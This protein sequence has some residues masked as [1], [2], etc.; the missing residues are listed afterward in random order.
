MDQISL[1]CIAIMSPGDMGHAVGRVLHGSGL[2]VITCLNGRSERTRRLARTASISEVESLEGLVTKADLI[3]S[4]LPPASAVAMA[5]DTA[6]AMRKASVKPYYADCNAVAPKTARRIGEIISSAGGRFIDA[7]IVGPPPGRSDP[8][9]FYASGPH[10]EAMSP[11]DGK[12]IAVHVIPGNIGQASGL[13]MCYAA[14]TK[15]TY[16]I[17]FALLTAAKIM[18]CSDELAAEF[19]YSQPEP[20]R[21]ME[22][23]LPKLPSKAYR[24]VGE[25]E[26]IAATFEQLGVTP[27]PH[28]GA[29]EIYSLL[30]RTEIANET[31]ETIDTARSL[32]ETIDALV[33]AVHDSASDPADE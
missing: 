20:H 4:I 11:L 26:E 31:P 9:R 21:R 8:P 16:A 30:S 1:K 2:D 6:S 25:M 12:G 15:G 7:G 14:M 28:R 24:W 17:Y 10:A 13:K 33:A 23:D 27:L 18:G 19:R 29:A 5:G 3:L 22:S 32:S